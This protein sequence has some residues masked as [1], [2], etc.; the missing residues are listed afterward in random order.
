M[1]PSAQT[2]DALIKGGFAH[3]IV[4]GG[5]PV[6]VGHFLYFFGE[7]QLS[8]EDDMVGSRFPCQVCLGF[9]GNG[10]EDV[11]AQL[12]HHLEQQ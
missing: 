11:P 6:T 5:Y 10:G 1:A 4:Y 9:G 7:V 3:G 12:F 8:V 2:T